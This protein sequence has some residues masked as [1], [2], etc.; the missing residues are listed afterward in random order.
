MLGLINV[1]RTENT[2]E[3]KSAKEKMTLLWRGRLITEPRST[4]KKHTTKTNKSVSQ[5]TYKC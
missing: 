2:M 3:Q 4:W 5:Q 1:T